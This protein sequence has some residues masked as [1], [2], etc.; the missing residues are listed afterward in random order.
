[1]KSHT[2]EE[3]ELFFKEIAD[4]TFNHETDTNNNAWVSPYK[5]GKALEKV[6]P[7]WWKLITK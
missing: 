7:D 1:M 3:L 4:L 6:D 2:S 5:L